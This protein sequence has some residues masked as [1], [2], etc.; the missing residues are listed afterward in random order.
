VVFLG[1]IKVRGHLDGDV[2]PHRTALLAGLLG[3][4]LLFLR[5]D[6]DRRPVLGSPPPGIGRGVGSEKILEQ[7]LVGPFVSVKSYPDGLGVVLDVPVRR[8]LIGRVVRVPGGASRV[9]DDRFDNALLAI[10]I[11]LRTPE[12]SH[13]RLEGRV[14]VLGG[15]QERA[16]LSGLGFL[17]GEHIIVV[18]FHHVVLE[19]V[20]T[21]TVIVIVVTIG[22]C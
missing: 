12:S 15:R 6:K 9:S 19:I 22:D 10:V 8:V 7:L 5:V 18:L 11:A 14:D 13:G 21:V 2:L 20:V 17:G 16:D 3:Q 1:A 4:E